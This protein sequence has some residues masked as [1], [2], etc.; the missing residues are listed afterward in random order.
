[1]S[2]PP[3]SGPPTA[4][5]TTTTEGKIQLAGDLGGTA[6]SPLV[7]SR[8][9]TATVA[10]TGVADFVCSNY[11]SDDLAVAA[12]VASGTEV[13]LRA[14]T[15]AFAAPVAIPSSCTIRGE[16][17]GA[18]IVTLTTNAN[19]NIFINSNTGG[20][21]TDITITDLT[22]DGNK[23]N[24]SNAQPPINPSVGGKG[25]FFNNVS[26]PVIFN[27]DIHD[28]YNRAIHYVACTDGHIDNCEGRDC[29]IFQEQ[30][31]TIESSTKC[32]YVNCFASG[33]TDRNF[34]IAF[35]SHI[36][37]I[38]CTADTS[39]TGA[40]LAI[41][42]TGTANQDIMVDGFTSIG[43]GSEGIYLERVQNSTFSNIYIV[44]P[45]T[46][47]IKNYGT[48]SQMQDNVFS[49]ITVISPVSSG[50]TT[51]T[52]RAV[53]NNVKVYNAGG[54]GIRTTAAEARLSN[55]HVNT[56]GKNCYLIQGSNS[57]VTGSLGKNGG[58][59][60]TANQTNGIRVEGLHCQFTDNDLFDDQG[61]KTQTHGIREFN[62]ADFN[63]IDGNSLL[64]NLTASLVTIGTNTIVGI[65]NSTDMTL[66]GSAGRTIGLTRGVAGIG[67]SLTV[68]SASAGVNTTDQN[69]GNVIV[70]TG[71]ATGN[72][73]SNVDI[74]AVIPNQ[75]TGHSDRA[76][77]LMARFTGSS[78]G[79]LVLGT[80]TPT[81]LVLDGFSMEG[82]HSHGVGT[83][84]NP[85]SNT[86][87]NNTTFFSGGATVQGTNRG[88]GTVVM[89]TGVSTGS[90][91]GSAIIQTAAPTS[92]T[93]TALQ[94]IT[95]NAEGSGYTAADVLTVTGGSGSGGTATVGTVAVAGQLATAAT[96]AAGT[97][98]TIGDV[99]TIAGGTSG[100]VTVTTID[101]NGGVIKTSLSAGGSGYSAVT[102]ATVTGGTG[103]GATFNTTIHNTGGILTISITA[104]G[105]G[106]LLTTG[107]ATTGGTGTGATLNLVPYSN[108]DNTPA[109]RMTITS[110][111]IDVTS[112]PIT[113]VANPTNA[114]DAAT[115]NYVDTSAALSLPA[116]KT[117]ATVASGF[118][119]DYYCDGTADDVQIQ[120]ANDA[121]ATYGGG[122]VLIR[123]GNYSISTVINVS[124]KVKFVGEGWGSILTLASAGTIFKLID[125]VST[126]FLVQN[127]FENLHF[128]GGG[129]ASSRAID[130]GAYGQEIA[131][132][133][134]R[135]FNFGGRHASTS[136]SCLYIGGTNK[137]VQI[138]GNWFG[139]SGNGNDTPIVM[140]G[141]GDLQVVGNNFHDF[142]NAINGNCEKAQIVGN[143]IYN[144]DN[145][146]INVGTATGGLEIIN[147]VGNTV[148]DCGGNG[149]RVGQSAGTGTNI[150]G[151]FFRN[152]DL[153]AIWLR[154]SNHTVI[155]NYLQDIAR[156]GNGNNAVGISLNDGCQ[157]VKVHDNNIL[158]SGTN[159]TYGVAVLDTAT[160]D[161]SIR[162]NSVTGAQIADLRFPTTSTNAY[163]DDHLLTLDSGASYAQ[164]LGR[165]SDVSQSGFNYTLQAGGVASRSANKSG[166]NLIF[167]SGQ[168]TGSG[169]NG[170]TWQTATPSSNTGVISTITSV[171]SGSV[172]PYTGSGYT[173]S[174]VLTITGGGGSGGT[175]TVGTVA[176]A[177]SIAVL[178][179]NALG[180]GY[181]DG[182]TLTVST[183]GANATIKVRVGNYS[184]NIEYISITAA[185]SG[186]STGTSVATTGGT[187]TGAT[188]DITTIKPTGAVLTA[189]LTSGGTGYSYT[190]AATTTGGTGTGAVFDIIPFDN[191]D[192]GFTTRATLDN[193]QFSN[194]GYM[195]VG[196]T[197]APVNT[198][199]GDLTAIRLSLGNATL[200]TTNGQLASIQGTITDTA[201]GA[202]VGQGII[203]TVN[204]ASA[205]SSEFR[206]TN[207]S[208]RG[209]G[210]NNLSTLDSLYIDTRQGGSGN[211]T[212]AQGSTVQ[213]VVVTNATYSG[214]ITTAVGQ[215]ITAVSQSGNPTGGTVTN[216]KGILIND[217]NKG[218]GGMAVTNQFGQDIAAQTQGST[219]NVGLRI[220]APN[221]ATNNYALQLSDTGATAAGGLTFGTDTQ[222]YRSGTNALNFGVAQLNSLGNLE[223]D[224]SAVRDITVGQSASTGNN[225]IV[226]SGNSA[227][228][229]TDTGGGAL[230]LKANAGTGNNTAGFIAFYTPVAGG[231]GTTTQ[232]V[233]ERMR[234]SA[235][236]NVRLSLGT[237][238]SQDGIGLVGTNAQN[239]GMFRHT[240][241]NTAGNN[242][243]I[244]S[245][246]ATS[247]ATNKVAGNL[248]LK[249]GIST[250]SGTAN[251]Q[252][253]VTQS[254]AGSTSD[255]A[256]TT[257]GTFAIANL[258]VAD[259]YDIVLGTTTG[260]K[261]G[262]A[263]SQKLGFF[264]ATPVV[265]EA[266]ATDLGV[267][268]SDLGL[269][270]AGTAWPLTT[271]GN[272]SFGNVT[273]GTAGNKISITTGS[274]ASA[275]TGT[276]TAGTVTISTT[277]VTANSLIFLTD[278]AS[279]LVNVGTL[280]VTSKSAGTSF[281]V[282]SSNIADTSTFNWLL[283]N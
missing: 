1:M 136:S 68:Q 143:D 66:D 230:L 43:S 283:I 34:E 222:V 182:D 216:A 117:V 145:N 193:N 253:Q 266:A 105:T 235:T 138:I 123:A 83:N 248:V 215:N 199:V 246:G 21:N 132:T 195:R 137:K 15:Y 262:T 27:V 162:N 42:S 169:V 275:G 94:A 191:S 198:T 10:K 29:G 74:Y 20:G 121:V 176:P 65:N 128:E 22:I 267:V 51:D 252:L 112:L 85:T 147:I 72:G 271:T 209:A 167:R 196:S 62:A 108:A 238:S 86:P 33:G 91:G 257:V 97:G 32:F 24:Q 131:V 63:L 160:G 19:C 135:F 130:C 50:I 80:N 256:F 203:T 55:C 280:S 276:L 38:N 99:L 67:S 194:T 64:G 172:G 243:T 39:P 40:S 122:T 188:V 70:S 7:K 151:N 281:T 77:Q 224:G 236:S 90:G 134:C 142:W 264:N 178:A 129:Y 8:A 251:I 270:A 150:T 244:Q 98:Y 84:R 206:T 17:R 226:Q 241:S 139:D 225:L 58:Q 114:Q 232:T 260:T 35:S 124:P 146:G 217:S 231:S 56:A 207:F 245:G 161:N 156:I 100:T 186:Y 255:N 49:N 197:S 158:N 69:A 228:G 102:G 44:S 18:T 107:A 210:S 174:D 242:L 73:T 12:A 106:Y 16:G 214:T 6:S 93:L 28:T 213:G 263:T 183:G 30:V 26:R 92:N 140:S 163:E 87:G 185:G 229:G 201:S 164:S 218:S 110:T 3:F 9:V 46:D 221:G 89:S 48:G 274:N 53:F 14:G 36:K 233:S 247:G 81:G 277:A 187:G 250:G 103:T 125:G 119:A 157:Y 76:A 272:V 11:A 179:I 249:T 95:V 111:G 177:G 148:S 127:D 45:A 52:T 116:V 205:S 180:S 234:L 115:K 141:V 166:G 101:V 75:G 37:V 155:G 165:N 269:R 219:L 159:M 5:A 104:A 190:L 59:L 41:Y 208:A 237:T 113:S 258:T 223:I 181:T 144:G 78:A 4:P 57:S 154:G 82:N 189:S 118:I 282:T 261:I 23:A 204:P 212:T 71:S 133:G 88:A 220:A 192:T 31:F 273:L 259:P 2:I 279:S 120:A 79:R 152:I 200:G 149:V 60:A 171:S 173:A 240:T 153:S 61:T 96:N 25:I 211:I 184:H 268:L 168:S 202:T 47:G 278:T 239:M 265:Q 175:V 13:R 227:T 126:G 170:F 254:T 109:T 54:D